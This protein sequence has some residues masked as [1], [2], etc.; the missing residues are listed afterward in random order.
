MQSLPTLVHPSNFD[1]IESVQKAI[2][3]ENLM[4]A[5]DFHDTLLDTKVKDYNVLTSILAE[6]AKESHT[7]ILSRGTN[8][9]L[10]PQLGKIQHLILAS[11]QGL[12]TFSSGKLIKEAD[13]DTFEQAKNINEF[14]PDLLKDYCA[15]E[16]G[17]NYLQNMVIVPNNAYACMIAVKK[18]TEVPKD[19][20]RGLHRAFLNKLEVEKLDGWDV[21]IT[22]NDRLISI[23]KKN[24][25]KGTFL[26]KYMDEAKKEF[27][28][29]VSL[30]DG[31]ADEPMFAETNSK[32]FMSV[33]V[34]NPSTKSQIKTVAKFYVQG[35]VDDARE[36]IKYITKKR[37]LLKST[38][39]ATG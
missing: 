22:K 9:D 26:K 7:V 32:N 16:N 19:F 3:A 23:Q 11:N 17:V 18:E 1:Q 31:D 15:K 12:R 10:E 36:L 6:A 27:D 38:K 21:L 4:I 24:W 2:E 25:D 28:Y 13:I 37:R 14:A 35:G 29:V 5:S 34:Q 8:Q 39:K 30:G 33:Y 20:V